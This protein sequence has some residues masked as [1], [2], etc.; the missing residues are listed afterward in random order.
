MSKKYLS[1]KEIVGKQVID[2]KAMIL[3][4]VKE[5]SFDLET[6]D[7]G[8]TIETKDGNEIN[9]SSSDMR[10]IGDVIL[11]KKTRSEVETQDVVETKE[12]V[13]KIPPPPPPSPQP[14]KPGLCSVCGYQNEK[15]SKFCIKCGTKMN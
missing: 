4:N 12:I 11:L 15:T 3:G 9:V 13:E 6:R 1:R 2:S 14:A 7:I 10:S 8:L 5:L